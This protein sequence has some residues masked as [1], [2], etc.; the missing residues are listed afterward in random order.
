MKR[1]KNWTRMQRWYRKYN[2]IEQ[3][4]CAREGYAY[5]KREPRWRQ[6]RKLRNK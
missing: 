5:E 2:S 4:V 6:L 1:N 3:S